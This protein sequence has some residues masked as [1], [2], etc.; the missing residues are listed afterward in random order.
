M[1]PQL[2]F[3]H[4]N[5]SLDFLKKSL[6][7]IFLLNF[8]CSE[9]MDEEVIARVD[10]F[11]VYLTEFQ[12]RY[13]FNPHLYKISDTTLAKKMVLSALIAEKLLYL[14]EKENQETETICHQYLRESMIEQLRRDSVESTIGINENEMWR[15]LDKCGREI[16]ITFIALG[17]ES[18][19]MKLY[20]EIRRTGSFEKAVRI[21]MD[22]KGWQNIPIPDKK[23]CWGEEAYPLEDTIFTLKNGEISKPVYSKGEYYIIKANRII[24]LFSPGISEFTRRKAAIEDRIRRKKIAKQYQIF[25]DKNIRQRLGNID[26]PAIKS[27]ISAITLY[28]NDKIPLIQ[29]K[30]SPLSD[31]QHKSLKDQLKREWDSPVVRFNN[32]DSWPMGELIGRLKAGPYVF[33]FKNNIDFRNSLIFNIQLLLEHQAIY[34][35]SRELGYEKNMQVKKEYLM[36]RSYFYASHHRFRLLQELRADHNEERL[37][38]DAP[39]RDLQEKRLDYL[40]RYITS[41]SKNTPIKINKKLLDSII[42]NKWDMVV[43]KIHFPGR[44]VAP[45]LEPLFGMPHWSQ[46][47]DAIL[48]ENN[49][50]SFK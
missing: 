14:S 15:E 4:S 25:Y 43:R 29:M 45:P 22:L 26:W 36:W 13:N 42:L 31:M 37:H 2:F 16:D 47:F 38:Q 24:Q 27:I 19:A 17:S 28:D 12:Y 44:L 9:K 39:G 30:K 1:N 21:F 7:F 33:D 34:L 40:D 50:H 18:E 11:P 46:R 49:V 41:I 48:L 20:K 5:F 8:H 3:M 32:G 23:V 10:H 6:I 35:M